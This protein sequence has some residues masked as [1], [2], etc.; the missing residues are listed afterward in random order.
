MPVCKTKQ[1]EDA[2]VELNIRTIDCV[3]IIL[4]GYAYFCL[5]DQFW[6]VLCEHLR[7]LQKIK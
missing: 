2:L 1:R 5:N 4:I 7:A 6:F 3:K